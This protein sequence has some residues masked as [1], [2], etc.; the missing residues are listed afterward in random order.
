MR[1]LRAFVQALALTSCAAVKFFGY[2]G[3]N[4]TANSQYS[5]LYQ[6]DT[7]AEALA[8]HAAGQVSLLGVYG[9][10]FTGA[11][12]ATVLLPDWQAQWAAL[13]AEAAP[14]LQSG[15]LLGFNL[16]G[17]GCVCVRASGGVAAVSS[18]SSSS[19]PSFRR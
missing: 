10:F 8:A 13:A 3:A 4:L 7:I 1:S 18:P 9:A 12:N 2:Y 15:V 6:A 16:G 11:V 17:C 5:N 14:H 19:S